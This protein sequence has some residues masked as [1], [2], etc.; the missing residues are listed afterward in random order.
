MLMWSLSTPWQSLA[1]N[2]FEA[3]WPRRLSLLRWLWSGDSRR[4]TTRPSRI[5][6]EDWPKCNR[7]WPGRLALWRVASWL[8]SQLARRVLAQQQLR[9]AHDGASSLPR[10]MMAW[11]VCEQ[12]PCRAP[13]RHARSLSSLREIAARAVA[14]WQPLT[15]ASMT[16]RMMSEHFTERYGS[17]ARHT[18]QSWRRWS[19]CVAAAA[20]QIWSCR[21]PYEISGSGWRPWRRP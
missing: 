21:P 13:L 18:E 4:A 15:P 6:R 2:A 3:R 8:S 7:N 12:M 17:W 19:S 14:A 5:W 10:L 11:C 20:L 1:R 16:S 9:L